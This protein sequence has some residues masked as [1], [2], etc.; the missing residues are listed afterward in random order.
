[1][2]SGKPHPN[3][4]GYQS[5][6]RPAGMRPAVGRRGST[7]NR[8]RGTR[9]LRIIMDLHFVH[10]VMTAQAPSLRNGQSGAEYKKSAF[11]A[12]SLYFLSIENK[13]RS[14]INR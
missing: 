7:S 4:T 12:D 1:M 6:M 10:F 8:T 14:L 13:A 11:Q 9:I 5:G 3:Q 2:H